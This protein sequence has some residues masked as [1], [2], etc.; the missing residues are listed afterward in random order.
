MFKKLKEWL[1]DNW[2][3]QHWKEQQ[4]NNVSTTRSWVEL[5][6]NDGEDTETSDSDW[7]LNSAMTLRVFANQINV[8]EFEASRDL[9]GTWITVKVG[10]KGFTI[11]Q[12]DGT[13]SFLSALING[14]QELKTFTD[15]DTKEAIVSDITKD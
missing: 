3:T 7:I 10:D 8:M 5:S 13:I 12:E 1:F 15:L 4:E 11:A 6:K 2:S 14:L 9:W